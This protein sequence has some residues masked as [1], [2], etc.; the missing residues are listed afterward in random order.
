MKA[1]DANHKHHEQIG[2]L[3]QVRIELERKRFLVLPEVS[4]K[5]GATHETDDVLDLVLNDSAWLFSVP[6]ASFR[7]VVRV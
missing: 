5:V 4:R 6:I 3:A 7:P 1:S 2:S